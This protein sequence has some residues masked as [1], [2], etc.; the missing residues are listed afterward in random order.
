MRITLEQIDLGNPEQPSVYIHYEQPRQRLKSRL[1]ALPADFAAT[2][3]VYLRRYQPRERLFECTPRNL[4]YVLHNVTALAGLR[5]KVTFEML[6]WTSAVR[7]FQDGMAED[8][9][10]RRLGLSQMAWRQTL[11]VIEQLAE[12]PL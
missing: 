4:E 2:L 12:G 5:H 11:P 7:S 3:E 8:R 10:R 6:R 1:L 9:L